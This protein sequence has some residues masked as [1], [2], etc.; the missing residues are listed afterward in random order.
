M[1]PK[2][3]LGGI[4]HA[5]GN[6]DVLLGRDA[7][8]AWHPGNRIFRC[9]VEKSICQIKHSATKRIDKGSIAI[10]I[11]RFI[12]R[13]GGRFLVR[14]KINAE[15]ESHGC[16]FGWK[17]ISNKDACRRA[18]AALRDRATKKV[19]CQIKAK[20]SAPV[21][22]FRADEQRDDLAESKREPLDK[23]SREG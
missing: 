4:V 12:R 23:E 19:R 5:I 9:L 7:P 21:F 6:S 10:L 14:T 22:K 15:T 8:S 1:Y 18:Y 16:Y 11:V 17:E 20:E 2:N 3:Q 13:R